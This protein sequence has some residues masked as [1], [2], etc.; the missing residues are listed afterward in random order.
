MKKHEHSLRDMWNTSKSN[1]VHVME[2][3][4]KEVKE[5]GTE[6]KFKGKIAENFPALMENTKLYIQEIP[7]TPERINVRRSTSRDIM[8]K[9]LKA[10]DKDKILKSEG[11]VNHHVQMDINKTNS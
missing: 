5:N 7:Q 10:E 6:N 8:V 11:K 3:P 2:V 9:M 4:E 1:D